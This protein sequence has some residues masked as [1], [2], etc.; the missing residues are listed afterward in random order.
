VSAASSSS[1]R[2]KRSGLDLEPQIL[3]VFQCLATAKKLNKSC[4]GHKRRAALH[5]VKVDAARGE[6]EPRTG[7]NPRH[8]ICSEIFEDTATHP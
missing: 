7:C 6:S 2:S 1:L 8:A 3:C 5:A 4:V